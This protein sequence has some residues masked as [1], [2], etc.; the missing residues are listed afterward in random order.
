MRA[1]YPVLR[2][3]CLVGVQGNHYLQ[4]NENKRRVPELS[5]SIESHSVW[6]ASFPRLALLPFRPRDSSSPRI[7][8]PCSCC[9]PASPL[10]LAPSRCQQLVPLLICSL[11]LLVP[12]S[13]AAQLTKFLRLVLHGVALT[14]AVPA[15]HAHCC[16]SLYQTCFL[17]TLHTAALGAGTFRCPVL[18]LV[19]KCECLQG[20]SIMKH[21]FF[22]SQFC[23]QLFHLF[24]LW[25]ISVGTT[26]FMN[27]LYVVFSRSWEWTVAYHQG[28]ISSVN[29]KISTPALFVG[30][31]SPVCHLRIL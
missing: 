25:G 17:L 7:K 3:Y 20:S 13:A 22:C 31:S 15:G 16:D 23:V 14:V 28:W 29:P 24:H 21:L 18:S 19:L 1:I 11:L 27:V 26:V 2:K 12:V 5:I 10:P 9:P 6:A 8:S 4:A 30:F